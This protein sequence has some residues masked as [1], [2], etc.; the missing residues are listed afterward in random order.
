MI[1]DS[2][3]AVVQER[4]AREGRTQRENEGHEPV[5]S[6]P[7]IE[8][9]R[10]HRILTVLLIYAGAVGAS[11]CTQHG[12]RRAIPTAASVRRLLREQAPKRR[13]D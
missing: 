8:F 13:N 12:A 2:C 7:L 11:A 6:K 3:G 4:P 10:R 1:T 5:L 9:A